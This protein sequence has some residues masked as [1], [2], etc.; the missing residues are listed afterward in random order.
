M[1]LEPT[2]HKLY[3]FFFQIFSCKK[4]THQI[5]LTLIILNIIRYF[6]RNYNLLHNFV[7]FNEK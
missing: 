6:D 2:D 7:F 5:Q 1:N 4:K 3:N